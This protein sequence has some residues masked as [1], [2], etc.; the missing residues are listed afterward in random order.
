MTVKK[1]KDCMVS[2]EIECFEKDCPRKKL[3]HRRIPVENIK[4]QRRGEVKNK[5]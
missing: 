3:A 1:K 4:D 5:Q 2:I